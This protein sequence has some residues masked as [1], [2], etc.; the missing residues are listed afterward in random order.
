MECVRC[1]SRVD[2]NEK[3]LP[4]SHTASHY[5]GRGREGTRFSTDN[6]DTLC[7]GCHQIWGSTDREAYREFKL[8]QLGKKRFDLLTIQSRTY[9]KKDR[10][11]ELIKARELLKTVV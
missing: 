8:K 1:H 6:L 5:Y 2:L 10:A 4:V 9:H 11:M 3:N 7:F